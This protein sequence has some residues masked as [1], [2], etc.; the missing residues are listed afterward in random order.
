MSDFGGWLGPVEFMVIEFPEGKV[1]GEGFSRMVSLV[2]AGHILV[3]D[4]EFIS[5]SA[6]GEVAL[7]EADTLGIADGVD[8]SGFAGASAHLIDGDDVADAG[9][10]IEEG[11]VA[12]ILVYEVLT[13]LPMIAAWERSG[14]RLAATGGVEFDDLDAALDAAEKKD[15]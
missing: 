3:L 13:V 12:A 15:S 14:A 10:M 4:L 1:A 11:S 7:V 8:L 6:T 5:K 9:A 2:D